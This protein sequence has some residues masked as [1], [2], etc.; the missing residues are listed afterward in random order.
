VARDVSHDEVHEED[1]LLI[2]AVSLLVQRQRET[3]AWV[4]EQIDQAD[5]RAAS[6]ERHYAALESR[7]TGLE[8]QLDSLIRE[9][10]PGRGDAVVGQRLA[11]LREQVADLRSESDGRPPRSVPMSGAPAEPLPARREPDLYTAPPPSASAT[12]AYRPPPPPSASAPDAYRVA[13][14]P[15]G[16][17]APTASEAPP[18]P[19]SSPPPDASPA[20]A[21]SSA[22]SRP[23]LWD[24]TGP[25]SRDRFGLALIGLGVIGVLY[26]VLTQLRVG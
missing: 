6:V 10:E 2:E 14:A 11:R 4:A 9:V 13:P 3:E 20:T 23:S 1:N 15:S 7:L 5:E 17:P 22:G 16:S 19:P 25:T 24:L 18:T 12:D 26:A 8:E 21:T